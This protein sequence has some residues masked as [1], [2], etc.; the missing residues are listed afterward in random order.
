VTI[1]SEF[2]LLLNSPYLCSI[3]GKKL[4]KYAI[5][6]YYFDYQWKSKRCNL[7]DTLFIFNL[8]FIIEF[9]ELMYPGRN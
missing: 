3:K 1:L 8:A 2:T 6:V 7:R 5:R 4:D 9:I